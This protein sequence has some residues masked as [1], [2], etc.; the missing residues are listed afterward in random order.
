MKHACCGIDDVPRLARAMFIWV[1]SGGIADPAVFAR[2]PEIYAYGMVSWVL[3]ML[4]LVLL[5]FD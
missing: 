2:Q 5:R 1:C 3:R 4:C